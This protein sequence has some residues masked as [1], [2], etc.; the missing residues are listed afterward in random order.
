M[1]GELNSLKEGN[2]DPLQLTRKAAVYIRSQ[3]KKFQAQAN[4][5]WPLQPQELDKDYLPLTPFLTE[6]LKTLVAGDSEKELSSRLNRFIHSVSQDF[7]FAVSGG[8]STIPKHI[9]LPWTVK[10]LTGNVDLK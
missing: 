5:G 10:T 1:T 6:F 9:L 7:M 2:S 4:L 8:S 3:L